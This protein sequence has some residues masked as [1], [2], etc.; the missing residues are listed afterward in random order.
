MPARTTEAIVPRRLDTHRL[1][2]RR[3]Q[4]HPGRRSRDFHRDQSGGHAVAGT[5]PTRLRKRRD[6]MS[7]P[8][9]IWRTLGTASGSPN[10]RSL[11]TMML[12]LGAIVRSSRLSSGSATR[13]A[14]RV[15]KSVSCHRLDHLGRFLRRGTAFHPDRKQTLVE[16]VRPSAAIRALRHHLNWSQ[17]QQLCVHCAS[18][19][20]SGHLDRKWHRQDF[21]SS[22]PPVPRTTRP[23]E[24]IANIRSTLLFRKSRSSFGSTAR[25]RG[26]A[27][28]SSST[29]V[30][31]S[32][33]SNSKASSAP[34]PS[35]FASEALV[36]KSCIATTLVYPKR[37]FGNYRYRPVLA[38]NRKRPHDCG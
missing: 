20:N 2:N 38:T 36:T 25:P 1:Q 6:E 7:V 29:K 3:R 15:G 8:G 13:R 14:R 19:R 33:P 34:N 26:S 31:R 22:L 12:P 4:P 23:F 37:G 30:P 9:V 32:V 27:M 24:E 35:P 5:G 28:R 18:R 16:K 10:G 17:R 11:E 21:S